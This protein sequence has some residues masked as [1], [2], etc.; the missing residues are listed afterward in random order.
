MSNPNKSQNCTGPTDL[1]PKM[2]HVNQTG[3]ED[4]TGYSGY[5][6]RQE[7]RVNTSCLLIVLILLGLFI[8]S[9]IN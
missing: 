8:I 6:H 2:D 3:P 7:V 5:E 1:M 9:N 4:Y